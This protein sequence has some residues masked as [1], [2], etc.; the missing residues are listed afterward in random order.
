M[1]L[2]SVV[3]GGRVA[4][5]GGSS[6]RGSLDVN[7]GVYVGLFLR[8]DTRLSWSD[9]WVIRTRSGHVS[10]T[11]Y[12][13]GGGERTL[14]IGGA[15]MVSQPTWP[16]LCYCD[17]VDMQIHMRWMW[18]YWDRLMHWP[19]SW[20]ISGGRKGM[21][22]TFESSCPSISLRRGLAITHVIE[23]GFR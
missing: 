19:K 5:V 1:T 10:S 17:V 14:R 2:T 20:P 7:D 6:E 13:C 16:H 8:F 18:E 12:Y 3:G 11:T 9:L 22:P 21:I 4:D 23:G 15:T